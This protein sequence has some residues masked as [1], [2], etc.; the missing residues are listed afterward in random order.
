M[1]EKTAEPSPIEKNQANRLQ[2]PE[3]HKYGGIILTYEQKAQICLEMRP[4]LI[5]QAGN[6]KIFGQVAEDLVS[7]VI[8]GLFRNDVF[9]DK[10]INYLRRSMSNAIIDHYRRMK[11]HPE[12]GMSVD[13]ESAVIGKENIGDRASPTSV[14]PLFQE[15]IEIPES[16]IDKVWLAGVLEKIQKQLKPEDYEIFKL[17][18]EG[19]GATD[20]ANILGYYRKNGNA[21]EGLVKQRLNRIKARL[22]TFTD[23]IEELKEDTKIPT[24]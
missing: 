22:L 13:L 18:L 9:K 19:N 15:Q 2:N 5:A 20:I 10:A 21:N 4:E 17:S 1:A 8:E 14:Y 23:L 11:L 7:H 6:K 24:T 12:E 3:S 16:A